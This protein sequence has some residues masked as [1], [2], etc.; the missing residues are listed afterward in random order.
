MRGLPRAVRCA[1]AGT[2]LLSTLLPRTCVLC[3]DQAAEPFNLCTGCIHGLPKTQESCRR[4]ALPVP[5][6][7]PGTCARCTIAPPPFRRATAAFR[8]EE[9]VDTLIRQLKYQRDLAVAPTLGRLLGQRVVETGVGDSEC[10][11]PVPLHPRRLRTRGFNQSL[12]IAKS[13]ASTVGVPVKRHWVKRVRDT[14]V[15]SQTQGVGARLQNVRGAFTASSRLARFRSVTIVDDVVTTGST[16]AELA[17]VILA[18]GVESVDLWC[19]ARAEQGT[20]ASRLATASALDSMKSRR[21][22]T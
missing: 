17:R 8:Y 7:S 22:P 15:Q 4:C 13:L 12:E 19:V 10:I 9:P 3:G 6:S 18:Q 1:K 14:M 11:L 5:V 2:H 16:T 20:Q 21:G